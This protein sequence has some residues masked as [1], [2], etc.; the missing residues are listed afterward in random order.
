MDMELETPC[1]L[2]LNFHGGGFIKG[3]S[4]R[5]HRYC[6]YL[7]EEVGCL[8]WDIDYA[9]APE[10]RFPTG[11]MDCYYITRYAFEHAVELG[12]DQER[13]ALA[14]HSAGGNFVAAV[15]L[16]A[17]KE[18]AFRPSC[19][20]MEY[21][22]ADQTVSA[23]DK[24]SSE[25]AVDPWWIHRAQIE[26]EYVCFYCDES[27]KEDPLCSP[28]LADPVL[29]TSFPDSLIISAGKDTLQK[30]TEQFA[31]TLM[32][33]GVSVQQKRFS[34]AVHGFTT[35]R[36]EGWEEALALHRSFFRQHFNR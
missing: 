33:Q 25:L 10:N 16:K 24:L 6:S 32:E 15:M 13:I 12:I 11:L 21:F 17:I 27:Q 35:N 19:L 1:P 14:G 7:A 28:L 36:T 4:D 30:E 20:L 22:P 9:L 26:Q 3:R 31:A 5:D 18:R 34:E 2:I 8:V 29:F 23:V